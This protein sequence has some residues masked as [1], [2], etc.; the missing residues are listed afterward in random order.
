MFAE[1]GDA[2]RI[3]KRRREINSMLNGLL[4]RDF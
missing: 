4:P 1:I 3:V 2:L